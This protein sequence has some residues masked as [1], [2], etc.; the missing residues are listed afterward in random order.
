M[1][2]LASSFHSACSLAPPTA[3]WMPA[4]TSAMLL[5]EVRA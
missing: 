5:L 1:V 4:S 2:S 3:V